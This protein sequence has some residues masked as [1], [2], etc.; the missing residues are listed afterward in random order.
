MHLKLPLLLVFVVL[1]SA[2]TTG[3]AALQEDLGPKP[4]DESI[5][6]IHKANRADI[7][8]CF[9]KAAP[10]GLTRVEVELHLP[11]SGSP[12]SI[13][14]LDADAL[15]K[16]LVTCLEEVLTG[17]EYGDGR[18]GST[19]YQVLTYDA[20]TGEIA[21]DEPIDVYQ[22]WGL[23]GEEIESVFDQREPQ[24]DECYALGDDAPKGRV[25]LT[26]AINSEGQVA[27]AGIKSSTLGSEAIEDCLV[28]RAFEMEFPPPRGGGVVVFDLAFRFREGK[29]WVR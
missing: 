23:T 1:G 15:P 12:V 21:F 26:I 17:L 25:V 27:R 24:I 22:R 11:R 5:A 3:N 16:P 8:E 4:R 6:A 13:R 7:G 28:E 19:F 29:G 14:L 9:D 10:E 18:S 2:C 20:E